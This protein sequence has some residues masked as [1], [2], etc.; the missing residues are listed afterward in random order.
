M[1]IDESF[2]LGVW[3][4]DDGT[5]DDIAVGAPAWEAGLGPGMR[6]VAVDGRAWTPAV[7]SEQIQAAKGA[8]EPIEIA[9]QQGDLLR[10]FKVGYHDGERYPHL[11]RDAS[12]PDLLALILAPKGW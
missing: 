2:S 7:L 4:K 8:R 6:I 11:E 12:R 5:I 3:L 9:V 1:R 10:T